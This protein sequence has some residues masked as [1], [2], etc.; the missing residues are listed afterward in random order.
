MKTLITLYFRIL[1]LVSPK[2]AAQSAFNVFQKVRKKDIRD[3][4]KPF[5]DRARH[6]TIPF[7]NEPIDCYEFGN[8][9]HDIIILLH[10]WDSNAGSM[11]KFVDKLVQKNKRVISMNLPAHAFYKNSKTNLFICKTAFKTFLTSLP[12]SDKSI[13]IIS[14]SFGSAISGY[15]LSELNVKIDQLIF[16]TSPNYILDVF[17]EFKKKI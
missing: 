2:L 15:A 17:K 9:D 8:P 1:S 12:P 11:Y 13:S 7:E 3:R 14:H 6:F 16:L 5:Y 10:G 4:E